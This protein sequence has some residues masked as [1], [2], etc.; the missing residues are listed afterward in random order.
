MRNSSYSF[1]PILLKLYRCFCHDLKICMW[2]GYYPEI[3]F[4]HFYCNLNLVIFKCFYYQSEKIVG[5]LCAQ[6]HSCFGHGLKICMWFGYNPQIINNNG[7]GHKFSEFACL[8]CLGP[9]FQKMTHHFLLHGSLWPT[10]LEKNLKPCSDNSKY[11]T[12]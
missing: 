3:I 9:S 7:G 12:S 10:N 11:G 8:I 6:L 2:F 1:M 4:C 5:T